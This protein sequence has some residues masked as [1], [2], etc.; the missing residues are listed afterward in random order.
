MNFVAVSIAPEQIVS[1]TAPVERRAMAASAFTA[2]LNAFFI[3][4][5]A[6]V[7]TNIGLLTPLPAPFVFHPSQFTQAT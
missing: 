7:P 1:A 3:S 5:G 6:L 2:L 4:L